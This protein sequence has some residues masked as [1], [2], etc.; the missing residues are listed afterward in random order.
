MPDDL[1]GNGNGLAFYCAPNAELT[2][3]SFYQAF[4]VQ[5]FSSVDVPTLKAAI[6]QAKMSAETAPVIN[7][8]RWCLDIALLVQ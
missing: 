8:M 3:N 5:T 1:G 6:G 4:S 2:N 7:Y